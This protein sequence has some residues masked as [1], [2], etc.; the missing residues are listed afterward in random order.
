MKTIQQLERLKKIHQYIKVCN[1]GSPNNFAQK[2]NISESQLYNILD[3][4]KITGFPILYSRK[5]KSYI[6]ND[7]CDLEIVYSVQLITTT[8][9]IKIVGGSI[10]NHP[11]P[12]QLE[13][14]KL[15]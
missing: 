6:Y 13:W 12:M 4:L 15:F 9:K 3:D 11:T 8:E 2:L 7:Y 1:T 5:L 10:K 14:R